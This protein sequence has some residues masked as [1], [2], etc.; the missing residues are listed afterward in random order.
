MSQSKSAR[1]IDLFAD[2]LRQ[3]VPEA[4]NGN[5]WETEGLRSPALPCPAPHSGKRRGYSNANPADRD[6]TS[7][8]REFVRQWRQVKLLEFEAIADATRNWP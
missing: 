5:R 4:E 7:A 3:M 2:A 8:N 6:D 1:K